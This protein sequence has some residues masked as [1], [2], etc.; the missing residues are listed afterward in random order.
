[1]SSKKWDRAFNTVGT[2]FIDM[3]KLAFGSLI[4]GVLLN[5]NVDRFILFIFGVVIIAVLF[6]TGILLIS[7]SEE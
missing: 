2:I 6:F 4:L 7:M 5:D 3:G 1:M